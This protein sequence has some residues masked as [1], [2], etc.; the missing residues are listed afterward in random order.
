MWKS[1]SNR[2]QK[3]ILACLGKTKKP[4]LV[5]LYSGKWRAFNTVIIIVN[6]IRLIKAAAIS[7]ICA[8]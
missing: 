1:V 6:V 5:L 4:V 8:Q 3:S 2:N 7:D